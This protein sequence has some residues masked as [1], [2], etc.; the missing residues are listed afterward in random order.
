MLFFNLLFNGCHQL[1]GGNTQCICNSEKG[2][3]RGL[4]LATLN[5][6]EVRAADAGKSADDL[7]GFFLFLPITLDDHS[8]NCCVKH[9]NAP[10]FFLE[11][12]GKCKKS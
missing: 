4:S 12:K 8:D 10:L 7:L 3:Q 1:A 6:A 9:K 2:F 11:C 5:G